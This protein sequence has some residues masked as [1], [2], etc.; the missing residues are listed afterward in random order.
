M[1]RE[2]PLHPPQDRGLWD[3]PEKVK[4][5][6]GYLGLFIFSLLKSSEKSQMEVVM[7]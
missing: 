1:R 6:M 5:R 4:S 3:D 2:P 7:C